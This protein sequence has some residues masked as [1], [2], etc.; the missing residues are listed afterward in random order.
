MAT[1]L[2][3]VLGV[4]KTATA[5]EIKKA[6]RKLARELH[7]DVNP[8]Q[9]AQERF[10]QVTAAYEVLS[11]DQQRAKYDRGGADEF[12]GYGANG[13]DLG[14]FV[15][16]F[17]GGAG[18]Q[19]GHA[20]ARRIGVVEH[21]VGEHH[22]GRVVQQRCVVDGIDHQA[23]GMAGRA[24]RTAVDKTCI[25]LCTVAATGAVPG[26]QRDRAGYELCSGERPAGARRDSRPR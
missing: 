17:F 13:F 25:G 3:G 21:Q 22:R 15:N 26:A 14:D 12:G 1:D 16:A 7:P 18:N 5:D 24:E 19:R 4:G 2:Y 8:D 10:K 23:G 20:Q 6:Y 11:D 9:S